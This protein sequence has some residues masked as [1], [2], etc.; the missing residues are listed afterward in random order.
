VHEHDGLAGAAL[1]EG[2]LDAARLDRRDA[3]LT[4]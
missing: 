3:H 4:G 2:E 1:V